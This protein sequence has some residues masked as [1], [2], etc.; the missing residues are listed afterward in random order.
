MGGK[1]WWWDHS[2]EIRPDPMTGRRVL[3]TGWRVLMTGW[4]VLKMTGWRVLK[5]GWRVLLDMHFNSSLSCT[6]LPRC[7]EMHPSRLQYTFLAGCLDIHLL[8]ERHIL[9][10]P[11]VMH[12]VILY[13]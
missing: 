1:G 2:W 12:F 4:R 10:C 11:V 5:T 6:S 3:M 7:F 9:F 13:L 8:A